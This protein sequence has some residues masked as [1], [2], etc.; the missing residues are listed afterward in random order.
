MSKLQKLL[1]ELTSG[2]E[3]RAEQAVAGL[4]D[5]GEDLI[6]LIIFLAIGGLISIVRGRKAFELPYVVWCILW[7]SLAM[8][9]F[10]WLGGA[11]L[12]RSYK[13]HREGRRKRDGLG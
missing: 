11:L 5:L 3:D 10:A 6:N 4:V 13:L 1:V 7:A 2:D 8:F 12:H 9:I